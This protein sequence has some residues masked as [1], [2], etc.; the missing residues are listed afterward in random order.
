VKE[1]KINQERYVDH[2]YF[3][4]IVIGAIVPIEIISIN[5]VHPIGKL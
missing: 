5:T 2:D 3:A 1:L 4:T